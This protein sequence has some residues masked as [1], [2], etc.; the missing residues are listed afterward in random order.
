MNTAAGNMLIY[1]KALLY[2][3]REEGYSQVR[4][5]CV[6]AEIHVYIAPYPHLEL[7]IL[8]AYIY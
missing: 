5:L 8:Y 6:N 2:Q 1:K 4:Q 7:P 3:R